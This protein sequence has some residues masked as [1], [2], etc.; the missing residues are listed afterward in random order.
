LPLISR[1]V[2]H[3][4]EKVTRDGKRTLMLFVE[5]DNFREV[6]ATRGIHGEKTRSNNTI[7]VSSKRSCNIG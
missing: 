4:N 5:G 1:V 2:I 7:E 3:E 6:M